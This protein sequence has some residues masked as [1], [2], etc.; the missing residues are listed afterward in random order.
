MK[1]YR[2]IIPSWAPLNAE[3]Q[4]ET[5]CLYPAFVQLGGRP[6]YAHIINSYQNIKKDAEIVVVL[7]E[8]SPELNFK[9]LDGFHV[10]LIRL[11]ESRNIGQTVLAAMDGLN[12][13]QAIVIHMADTLVEHL[14]ISSVENNI[15]YVQLRSD[16]YRW[17]SVRVGEAGAVRV[18]TDRDHLSA[19]IEST[20][21]VGVFLFSNG[22]QFTDH[23]RSALAEPKLTMDP[24]F[25]AI[26]NYSNQHSIELKKISS[27]HDFG[28]LDSYYESRLN[29]QNLRHFN[30]L[31][32]DAERGLVTKR[33]VNVEAYRHQIRW[34]KQVPDELAWFLPRIYES[35]DGEVP[36]IT[37]ELLSL[38][39]V[40]DL[41]LNKRLDVG[42][43][44]YL[45]QK[46]R[47]IQ[48]AFQKYRFNCSIGKQIATE[49]YVEKTKN[50][51]VQFLEQQQGARN[52]WI[53]RAGKKITLNEVIIT[54]IDYAESNGLLELDALSPI[55]G[56]MCFS[57]LM[58]D[59]RTR[60]IKLIDPRGE[61]GVPGIYGDVRYDKAKLM[62]SYEGSYDFIIA[63]QFNVA[64]SSDG[65]ISC[66]IE[67]SE[68]HDQVAKIF[69]KEIFE[70][71][72]DHRQCDAIQGLL[73]LSMLPLHSDHPERQLAMLYLGLDIYARN[74]DEP[75]SKK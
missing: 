35:D 74:F 50:R 67:R 4:A 63:S 48:T 72:R 30:T 6:L 42:A 7:P 31:T 13:E 16:I 20:V 29:Y 11:S 38:P 51:I 39:T 56:D 19:G 52:F 60:H 17:T 8:N 58:Y 53:R 14:E 57:N 68:Y 9:Y 75:W 10:Q 32:Y 40:S 70:N 47:L 34:F 36:Y 18:V 66:V 69:N 3:M 28:H 62:H 44:N 45:V 12:P 65:E 43:W 23:L 54:L 26:E 61:F 55:H 41:F 21:C 71:L 1:K 24:F 37:M 22:M 2:I 46:I 49:I 33:S 64:V 73:F 59:P 15:L 25:K 27:W 5:G